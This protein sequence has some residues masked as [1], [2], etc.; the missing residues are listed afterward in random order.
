MDRRDFLKKSGA[1]VAGGLLADLGIFERAAG[2]AEKA[3]RQPNIVFILVDEMRF[4]RVFPTGVHTPA[5]FL[6]RFM[7]NVF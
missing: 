3:S 2:A 4:P 7:P 6:R 5:G 1:V